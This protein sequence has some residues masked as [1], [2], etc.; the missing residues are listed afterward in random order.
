[1]NTRF[2]LNSYLNKILLLCVYTV[3]VFAAT[4]DFESLSDAEIIASQYSGLYFS[5]TKVFTSGVSLNEAEFPPQSGT[6]VAIDIGGPIT[7][8]FSKPVKNV[9]GRFTYNNQISLIGYDA[10]HS[11]VATV[12]STYSNNTKLSGV[13][14][15][16]PNELITL[17]YLS[18]ISFLEIKGNSSGGSLA[19]DDFSYVEIIPPACTYTLQPAAQNLQ[20]TGGNY[21]ANITTTTECGWQV[22]TSAPWIQITSATTGTGSFD[23][24]Y[25][26]SVNTGIDPRSSSLTLLSGANT[27]ATLTINQS[28]EPDTDS[29]G[30]VDSNDNCRLTANASQLDSDGD[31]FG[32]ACDADLNNDCKTNSL[33]LGKF[34]SVYGTN[35]GTPALKAAADFNGD[36]RVNSLD[37]G[38]FK[39]LFGKA[40]GP[41]GVAVCP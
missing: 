11:A 20:F 37:L 28:G 33:D 29:D 30:I 35:T 23:V 7:I 13:V 36:G 1:M 17:D 9:T 32:N 22:Q 15:S 12:T 21:L 38:L 39:K 5:N 31:H 3:N 27:L 34:K 14:G 16:T 2:L 10:S 19:L 6:K 18:G 8:S 26:V 24:Q 40:P 25:T 41:S 4:I